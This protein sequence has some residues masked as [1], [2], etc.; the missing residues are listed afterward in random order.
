MALASSS[1]Q[2][3]TPQ[4]HQ[5]NSRHLTA[6]STAAEPRLSWSL[7]LSELARPGLLHHHHP[8]SNT[9]LIFHDT[10]WIVKAPISETSH[11]DKGVRSKVLLSH[12]PHTIAA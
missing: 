3:H 6:A 10:L 2:A 8:N 9:L 5:N 4:R 7:Q 11:I 12:P 1:P